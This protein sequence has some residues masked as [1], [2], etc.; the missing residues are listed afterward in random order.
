MRPDAARVIEGVVVVVV[1]TTTRFIYS[2]FSSLL[3][4]ISTV[5]IGRDY[6]ARIAAPSRVV[7]YNGNPTRF[8]K[9][10]HFKWS[11]IGEDKRS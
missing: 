3:E 9:I 6:I 11:E 1:T 7:I 10:A 4:G 8:V 5:A 2:F